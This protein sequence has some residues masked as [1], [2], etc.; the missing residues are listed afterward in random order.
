M[1]RTVAEIQNTHRTGTD[2]KLSGV[3]LAIA[4]GRYAVPSSVLESPVGARA[5]SPKDFHELRK[6]FSPH[7]RTRT[8]LP[9]FRISHCFALNQR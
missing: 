4:S 6:G 8:R 1:Q 9:K 3:E 7:P 5:T 2:V